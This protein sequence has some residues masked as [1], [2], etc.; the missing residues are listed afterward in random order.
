MDPEISLSRFAGSST[1]G[2]LQ[3]S[4]GFLGQNGCEAVELNVQSDHIHLVVYV[5]PK[6]SIS[7]LM[8][9]IKGR[10]AIRIF[11]Q[12]PF[13]KKKPYWGNHL[14][15]KGYCV[16]TVGLDEDM[17][18]SYVKYQEKKERHQEQMEFDYT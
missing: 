7:K 10:S 15:A 18:R 3:L 12:F 17:I 14:W 9:I 6:M 2:G 13:L 11:T 5:P 4:S 16:D 8:G 1:T